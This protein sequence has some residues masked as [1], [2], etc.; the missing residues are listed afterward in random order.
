MHPQLND[1]HQESVWL[2]AVHQASWHNITQ[3]CAGISIIYDLMANRHHNNG[4]N[5]SIMIQLY[6]AIDAVHP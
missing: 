2:N 3:C 5:L 1:V 4:S 6:M